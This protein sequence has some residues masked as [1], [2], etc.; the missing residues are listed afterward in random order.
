LTRFRSVAPE[1]V[2]GK[3]TVQAIVDAYKKLNLHQIAADKL[4]NPGTPFGHGY[5]YFQLTARLVHHTLAGRLAAAA[6]AA[7]SL[8]SWQFFHIA[9]LSASWVWAL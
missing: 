2:P 6:S 1:P 5:G 7:H 4:S 3:T 8:I 9:P